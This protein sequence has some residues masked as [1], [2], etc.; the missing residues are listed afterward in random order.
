MLQALDAYWVCCDGMPKG[1]W[2]RGRYTAEDWW[3]RFEKY[4]AFVEWD[5][6][7]DANPG[8]TLEDMQT[9]RSAE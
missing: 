5:L 1:R 2:A 3:T 8:T 9:T 6:I 4:R 7:A